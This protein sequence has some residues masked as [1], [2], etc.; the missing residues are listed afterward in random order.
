M[1]TPC[2]DEIRR[3]DLVLAAVAGR[4]P[5][6]RPRA[7]LALLTGPYG[8]QR[9]AGTTVLWGAPPVDLD[10]RSRAAD[11]AAVRL[12]LDDAPWSGV[13]RPVL[14]PV[15]V[16]P[17]PSWWSWD[18]SEVAS[19]LRY[20]HH[21]WAVVRAGVATVT[22]RGWYLPEDGIWDTAPR[23]VWHRPAGGPAPATGAA[24]S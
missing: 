19:A 18:E 13:H 20:C 16:R 7:L 6:T 17:G 2:A 11:R 10:A 22:E 8:D 1:D 3:P 23:T 14:L 9:L 5:F 4:H 21:L 15:V 24:G 12:G